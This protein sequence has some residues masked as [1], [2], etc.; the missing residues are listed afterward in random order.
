MKASSVA[1]NRLVAEMA[2]QRRQVETLLSLGATARQAA[3]TVIPAAIKAGFIPS[4]D[5]MKS[6]G[7]VHLPGIMTGY[8]IAGGDPLT[9]VKFQLA[10][11]YMLAGTSGITCLVV[12]LM[13]YKKC[14]NSQ[15][16]LRPLGN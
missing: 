8:I 3:K 7:L 9:A 5:T 15:L 14:F 13:A 6:V 11:I 2:H 1:L 10:I 12:T 16:Q 4:L